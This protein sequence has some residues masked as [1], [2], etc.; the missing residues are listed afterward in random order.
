MLTPPDI[1]EGQGSIDWHRELTSVRGASGTGRGAFD[2][3]Q[4][5]TAGLCTPEGGQ[6]G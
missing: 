6:Q 4:R 2:R 3:A 1:S 5:A